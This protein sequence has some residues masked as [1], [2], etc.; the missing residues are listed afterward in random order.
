MIRAGRRSV[1]AGLL[2]GLGAIAL[3]KSI[4]WGTSGFQSGLAG[5]RVPE[6]AAYGGHSSAMVD[7]HS[8]R[9]AWLLPVAVAAGL[10]LAALISRWADHAVAGTDGVIASVNESRTDKLTFRGALVKLAATAATLG[11]GG[12][13]GTE[14]PVA[15]VASSL[16]AELARRIGLSRTDPATRVLVLAGL[17]AGVGALFRT[18]LGGTLLGVQILHG[19]FELEL[20]L[21]CAVASLCACLVFDLVLGFGP[22]LSHA[23]LGPFLRLADLLPLLALG[24]LCALL[25]RAYCFSLPYLGRVLAPLRESRRWFLPTAVG[26]GLLL[27]AAGVFVPEILGTGY[28]SVQNELSAQVLRTTPLWLLLLVPVGKLAATALTLNSG[29]VGGVFGPAMVIGGSAGALVWRCAED[30]GAHPGPAPLYVVAGVAACLG[31]ATRA[32]TATTFIA[33]G[34]VGAWIPP[35]GMVAAVLGASLLLGRAGLFPSQLTDKAYRRRDRY[36]IVRRIRTVASAG[37]GRKR[38]AQPPLVE[39]PV[40][41]D[42]ARSGEVGSG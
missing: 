36:A 5:L 24:V 19:A 35:L 42:S 26:A 41:L 27:G 4:Q 13:G 9:R 25:G 31:P 16:D 37:N 29:G 28:G 21:P 30:L 7:V 15:Q 1:V 17:A 34:L 12:S 38:G 11:S 8:L 33:T 22:M 3:L 6:V 23:G 20:L 2:A 18:P 32:A 14:G 40:C 39:Q 10:A